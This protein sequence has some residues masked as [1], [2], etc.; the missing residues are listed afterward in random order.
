ME[1]V[2]A[3]GVVTLRPI[4]A[5]DR[6][7]I[8]AYL[9]D[10]AMYGVRQIEHDVL[11]PLGEKAIED[12]IDEWSAA[13]TGIALGIVPAGSDDVAGHVMADWGWDPH[14]PWIGL[15]VA[16][17]HRRD[18]LGIAAAGLVITWLFGQTVAR[19]VHTWTPERNE[20]G[21]AFLSSV[22][23]SGAGAARR[24]WIRDGEWQD[25]LAFDLLK[26]EWEAP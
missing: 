11:A 16:P 10:P 17:V 20:A 12:L 18:G 26:R 21:I 5:A 2:F 13:R 19:S 9:N 15:A 24:A 7:A 4:T 8:A 1:D 25:D 14:N 22:G 6:G 23:L 3:D